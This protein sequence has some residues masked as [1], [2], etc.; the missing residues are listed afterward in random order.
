[1]ATDSTPLSAEHPFSSDVC[2]QGLHAG[3][4]TVTEEGASGREGGC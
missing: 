4:D 3:G 1:M 2:G